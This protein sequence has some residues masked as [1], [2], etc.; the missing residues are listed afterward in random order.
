MY[1]WGCIITN[2]CGKYPTKWRS[3]DSYGEINIRFL[4]HIIYKLNPRWNVGVKV[5]RIY[6]FRRKCMRISLWPLGREGF[7]KQDIK[8]QTIKKNSDRLII[9]KLKIL[10]AKYTSNMKKDV[11]D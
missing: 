1:D 4:P 3:S 9:L 10:I 6:V 2:Q 7:L 8:T 11:S 5:K